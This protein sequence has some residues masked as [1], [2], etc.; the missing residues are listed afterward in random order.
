MR[1][2]KMVG[3]RLKES[4]SDA[5]V[6]SH[7]FTI[8]GGYA[9]QVAAG[10]Y[11]I[12]PLGKRIIQKIENI[13]REEMN[14]IEGQEVTLPVVMPRELWE[15]SGRFTSV[16]PE[17]LRFKDRT[18]KDMLLGMTHEEAVVHLA[19]SEVSS[20][21]QLPC[22]M[23]QIQTKF[24]DEARS[25]AGLIR[26]RE[27]TM[28]DA[29]S[30]HRSQADLELYYDRCLMSY[31]R[32]FYRAGLKNVV[33]VKADSGMM[34]GAVSHE[35]ML[36]TPIGEDTLV[37]CKSCG[38]SAN[39]EVAACHRV[40]QQENKLLPLEE[41]ATPGFKTIEEVTGFLGKKPSETGKAVFFIDDNGRLVYVVVRGDLDVEESKV[42]KIALSK[43][44]RPAEDSEIRKIGCEPGFAGL[45]GA[46]FKDVLVIVDESVVNSE[47]L[48]VGANKK[49]F[50]YLN[51]NLK[52]DFNGKFVQ[53]DI[54]TV[55]DGELCIECGSPLIISR[56][57]EIGNI[58][59][60]GVKYSSAMG[61]KFLD[62]DQKEKETIM[63]C[64]GIGVGRLFAS[65]IED[66]HDDF[67]PVWPISISPYQVQLNVLNYKK[68]D[69][70][71]IADELYE[72]LIADGIE[73]LF[74]D[75]D[76]KAGFQFK[77]ADLMGIPLRIILS[78]KTIETGEAE[79]KLRSGGDS[80]RIKLELVSTELKQ[81]IK[82]MQEKLIPLF[83]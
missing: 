30:F 33:I 76:E 24:R 21:K 10:I 22:M 55:K 49:D 60:L 80:I 58:F 43:D 36:E 18:D 23:Y 6:V 71:K 57:I 34:G 66:C 32:I 44:L 68:E 3:R 70:K 7:Q 65:V 42:K 56:G 78:P 81:K 16:G 37:L 27:F 79:F 25:R 8:R 12:L 4:P 14:L 59:Q 31:R 54:A 41:V 52:R 28:K 40:Y 46:D 35:F 51:F 39:R 82:E 74:D 20:Y 48:V 64:Y 77:D 53:A 75:R 15:E 50:H 2:T 1:L 47:N 83:K 13:I 19:R 5:V 69:V 29:Y 67:G 63:G 38:Y 26:V 62:N 9:R 61:F 45:M 11:S 73:V 72:K 17:L